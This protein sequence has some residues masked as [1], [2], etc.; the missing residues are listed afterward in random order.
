MMKKIGEEVW[1]SQSTELLQIQPRVVADAEFIAPADMK[2]EFVEQIEPAPELKSGL[3]Q[4]TLNATL[5]SVNKDLKKLGMKMTKEDLEAAYNYGQFMTKF[6]QKNVTY[7]REH[8]L[9]NEKVIK[10]R[11]VYNIEEEWDF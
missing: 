5:K 3:V 1:S 11:I 7:M 6:H 9:L 8:N 2:I 10:E 4:M